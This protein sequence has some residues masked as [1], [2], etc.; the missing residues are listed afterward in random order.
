MNGSMRLAITIS[1]AIVGALV[2]F[3]ALL[4]TRRTDPATEAIDLVMC[5]IY[6]VGR[7]LPPMGDAGSKGFFIAV[8]IVNAALYGLVAHYLVQRFSTVE[9]I[10]PTNP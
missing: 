8:L 1:A 9:R 7:Y 10:R 2:P 6:V 4:F 3:R 5:P